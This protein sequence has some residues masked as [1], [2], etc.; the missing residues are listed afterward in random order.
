MS[1]MSLKS[2]IELIAII[3][4][5]SII[6]LKV[7]MHIIAIISLISIILN[8]FSLSLQEKAYQACCGGGQ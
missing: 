3:V 8:N 2:L 7:L 4:L 1:I 6:S 5:M